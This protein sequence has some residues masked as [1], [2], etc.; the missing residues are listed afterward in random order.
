[1][2]KLEALRKNKQVPLPAE[3][4]HRK[5]GQPTSPSCTPKEPHIR[6]PNG[7]KTIQNLRFRRRPRAIATRF[8][9]QKCSLKEAEKALHNTKKKP[10]IGSK[11][12]P[13]D[14]QG[15]QKQVMVAKDQKKRILASGYIQD[16]CQKG[17]KWNLQETPRRLKMKI[18]NQE[19][20]NMEVGYYLEAQGHAFEDQNA[21][22]WDTY[23]RT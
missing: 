21:C 1:M 17:S 13:G 18:L 7:T 2:E 8:Y 20:K 15:A 6:F 3:T 22:P 5:T 11:T 23:R 9:T 16:A 14:H 10:Q 12:K 19:P 4:F